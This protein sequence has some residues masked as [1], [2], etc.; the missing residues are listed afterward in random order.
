MEHIFKYFATGNQLQ[1]CD[2]KCYFNLN[3]RIREQS[4][5]FD[6]KPQT[7]NCIEN[8]IVTGLRFN[9]RCPL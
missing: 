7:G 2:N 8:E 6:M 1:P 5:K 9:A 3:L 4:I